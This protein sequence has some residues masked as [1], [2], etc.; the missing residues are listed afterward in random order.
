MSAPFLILIV[1]SELISLWILRGL[2]R[3]SRSR[4]EK[5]S[6]A[7]VLMLPVLGP[8]LFMLSWQRMCPLIIRFYETT[9]LVVVSRIA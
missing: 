5:F 2:L 6:L 9:V 4:L 1:V 8:F 7:L 3:S